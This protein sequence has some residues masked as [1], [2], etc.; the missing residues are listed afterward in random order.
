VFRLLNH[1]C[2]LIL[3]SPPKLFSDLDGF[4]HDGVF[5]SLDYHLR[6]NSHFFDIVHYFLKRFG[7]RF[8]SSQLVGER[9]KLGVDL[10]LLVLEVFV[11]CGQLHAEI[12]QLVVDLVV[13]DVVLESVV[14]VLLK[15]VLPVLKVFSKG[16]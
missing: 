12:L 1:L 13:S 5:E 3:V 8:S 6:L 7:E 2:E 14:D 9:L 10:D 15:L 16:F 4:N 11:L